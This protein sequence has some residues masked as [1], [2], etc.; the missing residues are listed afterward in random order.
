M[1]S[2]SPKEMTG[3][4]LWNYTQWEFAGHL[5]ALIQTGKGVEFHETLD[6]PDAWA[7]YQKAMLE[8]ARFDASIV[9][10]H[11]PVRQGATRLLDIGGSHGLTGAAICRK[12]PPMRSTVIDLP[13]AIPH[14]AALAR[15][16]GLADI[17]EHKAGDLRHDDFGAGW[18]VALLA[19]ILHHFR[20][21][22]MIAIL[23]RVGAALGPDATVAIWE[24]ERPGRSAAPGQ[25]DGVALFFRLTST[26]GAYSGDEYA[27]WLKQ[28]G[29][30]RTKIVR[31]R[32]SPGNVLVVGRAAR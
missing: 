12:H 32:L 22:E 28:A 4:V 10:K 27:G 7:H 5:E 14:A 26:A 6:D 30:V 21:D 19:N 23:T 29:F 24:R 11:V 8:T 13:A 15:H 16:E 25:G 1:V 2:G 3:F 9:A 18:D 31:P 17:V 20:P